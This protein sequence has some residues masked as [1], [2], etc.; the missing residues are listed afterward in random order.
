MAHV[1]QIQN[2]GHIPALH[3]YY[4]E[5]KTYIYLFFVLFRIHVTRRAR[6][7]KV[8]TREHWELF[9]HGVT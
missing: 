7:F 8:R 6:V 5:R 9:P 1:G 4:M 3:I 2:G